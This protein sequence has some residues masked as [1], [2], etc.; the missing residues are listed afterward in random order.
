MIGVIVL[1]SWSSYMTETSFQT[2]MISFS[3]FAIR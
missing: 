3:S 1:V 2:P